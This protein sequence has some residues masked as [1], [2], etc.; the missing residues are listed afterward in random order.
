MKTAFSLIAALAILPAA[1]AQ[2]ETMK[3]PAGDMKAMPA[4][5]EMTNG[6]IKKID[7][8]SGMLTI[9]HGP[10]KNLGMPGMTMAFNVKDSSMLKQVKVGDKVNFV[11]DMV[12]S[13]PTV[14]KIEQ[15]K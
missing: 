10:L 15:A 3:M 12:N 9:K 5:T 8:A 14:T 1:V 13:V 6:E 2:A 7:P 4:S 11:A